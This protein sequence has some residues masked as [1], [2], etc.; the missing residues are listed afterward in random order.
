MAKS[1]PKD[2]LGM[3][4]EKGIDLEKRRIYLFGDIDESASSR[5]IPSLHL[6]DTT[7]KPIEFYINSNGGEDFEMWAIHDAMKLCSCPIQTIAIGKCFSAAVLLVAAGVP[8]G[9]YCTRNVDFMVHH[10]SAGMEGGY[11]ELVKDVEQ[12][13][14]LTDRWLD[15]MA[16]YTKLTARKWKSLL[17]KGG[18]Y[19]MDYEAAIEAG[20][21]DSIWE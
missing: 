11:Q 1:I 13:G 17:D 19:Y 7:E 5:I 12:L 2:L 16:T 18:D 6:L 8:G 3:Y 20:I 15:H 4:I 10:S 14:R 21:V 9:R